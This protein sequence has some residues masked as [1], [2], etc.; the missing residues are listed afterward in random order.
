MWL[1]G[2]KVR[3]ALRRDRQH[4]VPDTVVGLI[5]IRGKIKL[6]VI[7]LVL[8]AGGIAPHRRA[9]RLGS[10]LAMHEVYAAAPHPEAA[11]AKAAAAVR[12]A[13]DGAAEAAE[14]TLMR[15]WSSCGTLS[16]CSWSV[17][18]VL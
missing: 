5:L 10:V 1:G 15:S 3:D 12:T 17:F 8:E 4:S 16:L 6:K 2:A 7:V 11:V 18:S 14:V 13:E 9:S